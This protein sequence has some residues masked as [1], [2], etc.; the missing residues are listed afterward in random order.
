MPPNLVANVVN[1]ERLDLPLDVL[2]FDPQNPRFSPSSSLDESDIVER[3]IDKERVIELINSISQQ[4]FFPG[5]P[6]LVA[7]SEGE[8]IVVEGNRRLAAL[9]LLSS[10]LAPK[11]S[12]PSIEEAR[13][14]AKFKPTVIPCLVFPHRNDIIRSLGFRH[15]TGI[16]AWEPLAKARYLSQLQEMY[17]ALPPDEQLKRLA[18]EIGSRPDYVGTA[19]TGLKLYNEAA[20]NHFFSLPE[21]REE[22]FDFSVLTTALGYQHIRRFLGLVSKKD[23]QAK[24]L[25]KDSLRALLG[26]MFVADQQ[27]DTVLGDS[28]NL[29]MLDKVLGV[30]AAHERLIKSLN[31]EEAYLFTD[32]PD[33]A[34]TTAL[35]SAYKSLRSAY[36][37]LL[38]VKL[39]SR[40]H[41]N[42]AQESFDIIKTIRNQIRDKRDV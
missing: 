4:G 9:K 36:E 37:I 5:E 6:L 19:L 7:R 34:L 28:R 33:E 38:Q 24:N 2:N 41:D 32:G 20:S 26:W 31:L 35:D 21:L 8:Y 15:I 10:R 12:R 11:N 16:K 27:G 3:M 13:A 40:L 17:S 14:N 18:V 39:P 30:S 29:R 25:D 22:T 23:S 42:A 1:S